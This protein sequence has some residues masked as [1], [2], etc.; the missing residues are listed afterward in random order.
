M[1]QEIA[2]AR[3]SVVIPAYDVYPFTDDNGNVLYSLC[4]RDQ[5]MLFLIE[6]ESN[7]STSLKNNITIFWIFF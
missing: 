4:V 7:Y 3:D 1:I 2:C 5:G 6:V